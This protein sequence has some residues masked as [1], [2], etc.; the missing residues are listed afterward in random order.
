MFHASALCASVIEATSTPY[1][2]SAN[3]PPGPLGLPAGTC[4]L[5]SLTELLVRV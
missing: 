5:A 2:L 4:D 3:P 1:R